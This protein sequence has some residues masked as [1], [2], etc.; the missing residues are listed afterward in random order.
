MVPGMWMNEYVQL[1]I[2]SHTGRARNQCWTFSSMKIPRRFSRE[3]SD[4][5]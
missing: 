3:M 5:A 2:F 4:R 1:M